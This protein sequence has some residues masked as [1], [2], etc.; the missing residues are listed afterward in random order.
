M[1]LMLIISVLLVASVIGVAIWR[2]KCLPDSISALVF[3]FL[4][5]EAV[6]K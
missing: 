1:T 5:E 6:I 2:M 4:N 3:V